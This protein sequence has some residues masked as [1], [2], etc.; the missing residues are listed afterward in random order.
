[1]FKIGD[2][3]KRVKVLSVTEFYY[4][5]VPYSSLSDEYGI[6]IDVE[7]PL[8]G[9]GHKEYVISEIDMFVKVKWQN[10]HEPASWH[11]G[12]EIAIVRPVYDINK[13][14]D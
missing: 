14:K 4:D 11:W 7:V 10:S 12:D 1:M 2:L 5:W 8:E 3:V 9:E 6:V 13:S